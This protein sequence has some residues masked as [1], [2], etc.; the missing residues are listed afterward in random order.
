M[1]ILLCR[2]TRSLSIACIYRI[3]LQ[4]MFCLWNSIRHSWVSACWLEVGL[5][6]YSVIILINYYGFSG[7]RQLIVFVGWSCSIV[8]MT[9]LFIVHPFSIPVYDDCRD[10]CIFVCVLRARLVVSPVICKYI[11]VIDLVYNVCRV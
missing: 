5:R 7:I 8:V 1:S 11:A 3:I 2:L 10:L 9:I 6:L 4:L